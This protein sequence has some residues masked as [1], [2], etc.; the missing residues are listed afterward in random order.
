MS[1]SNTRIVDVR[2]LK[3]LDLQ[4]DT[5]STSK[6]R[7]RRFV[8]L[9]KERKE[10]EARLDILKEEIKPLAEQ[11][12]EEFEESGT[13]RENVDGLTVYLS[14]QMWARPKDGDMPKLVDA[15]KNNGMGDL[16]QETV[17]INSLSA[18]VRERYKECVEQNIP[19]V[20]AFPAMVQDALAVST[21]RHLKSMT[22]SKS[23]SKGT[24]E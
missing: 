15:L 24:P 3:S 1:L 12:A 22:G 16:V 18:V 7:V 19:D 11:I 17:N 6:D 9:E 5:Q 10:L 2:E 20:L 21:S 23:R 8:Q 14:Y 4:Q 13:Q